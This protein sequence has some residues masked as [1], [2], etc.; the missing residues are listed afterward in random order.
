MSFR[1]K[2]SSLDY[3]RIEQIE[4]GAPDNN[5]PIEI[6]SDTLRQKLAS[7]ALKDAPVLTSDEL[8]RIVPHL[9]AA[10]AKAS[11]KEDVTF[12]ITGKHGLFGNVSPKTVTTARIFARDQ[13][14]HVIFGEMNDPYALAL[15]GTDILRPFTP[16]KRAERI[17]SRWVLSSGMGSFATADR[18]DWVSFNIARIEPLAEPTI[19]Q[20]FKSPQQPTILPV[21]KTTEEPASKP[22]QEPVSKP[23]VI[24]PSKQV[25]EPVSTGSRA[26]S[27]VDRR[28]EEINLRLSVLNRLKESGVI[29]EEEYRERRRAILQAL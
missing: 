12:A 4:P 10:L 21:S 5:H 6:S 14:L 28:T 13:R 17:D 26:T 18:P 29:T 23:I 27:E 15:Q 2:I 1:S 22:A 24:P 8:D 19:K 16:G 7:V 25:V 3:V 9:T 11:P 20:E